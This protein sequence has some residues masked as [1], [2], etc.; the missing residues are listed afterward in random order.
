MPEITVPRETLQALFDIAVNSLDFGSGFLDF[1]DAEHLRSVAALLGV[2]PMNGTPWNVRRHYPHAAKPY[3]GLSSYM[4]DKCS[5]CQEVVG[6]VIHHTPSDPSSSH[7][8]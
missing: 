4:S 3:D 6:N 8:T 5:I 1:E 7:R 2:D